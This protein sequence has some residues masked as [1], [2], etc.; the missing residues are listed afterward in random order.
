MNMDRAFAGL[1]RG[2]EVAYPEPAFAAK[3]MDL[4]D[5]LSRSLAAYKAGDDL[6]GGRLLNEFQ[7]HI[8]KD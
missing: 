3:R 7:D 2:I 1:Q 4:K 8:F 5:I 6:A